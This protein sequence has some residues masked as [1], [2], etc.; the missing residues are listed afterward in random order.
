MSFL[1]SLGGA[2][3]K[4]FES[5]LKPIGGMLGGITG[6]AGAEAA[7]Q[8]AEMQSQATQQAAQQQREMFDILN[9]QQAP[10]REA[11]YT[12]LRDIQAQMPALNRPFTAA[13]LQS[14]LSPAYQ[15]MLQQGLG[16]TRQ[17]A[18]VGGG[19][20]N[21][22]RAATKFAEDYAANAYQQAFQN[23]QQQQQN[24]YNRLASLAGIG[25]QAQGQ[26]QQLGTGVAGALGQLG[27]GGATALGAGQIG[28]A[29]A[30]GQGAMN[31]GQLAALA[32][33]ALA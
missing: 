12:A 21:V 1:S 29:G 33:M 9:R 18:N 3:A 19:G 24:I 32:K 30:Y 8:A 4:P 7:T 14:Q 10:Y 6:Q 27:I 31:I 11:G 22:E 15:F 16:A 13:D 26:Q 17:A 25:Q 28:A 2:I 5:V 23:Y 20:S